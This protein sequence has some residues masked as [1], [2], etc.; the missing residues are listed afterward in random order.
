MIRRGLAPLHKKDK[1]EKKRA[2]QNNRGI[3]NTTQTS[4]PDWNRYRCEN[5]MSSCI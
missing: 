5:N 3:Y 1:Y 4:T 2:G